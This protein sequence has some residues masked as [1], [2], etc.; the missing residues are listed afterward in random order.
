M[1]DNAEESSPTINLVMRIIIY[2]ALAGFL[3]LIASKA[4][5]VLLP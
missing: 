2:L 1:D 3:V 5:K 4:T